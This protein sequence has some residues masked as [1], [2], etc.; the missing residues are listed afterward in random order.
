MKTYLY[1]H[2]LSHNILLDRHN[3]TLIGLNSKAG[4]YI[5][6]LKVNNADDT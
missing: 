3:V 6:N 1:I 4:K 2:M 5:Q